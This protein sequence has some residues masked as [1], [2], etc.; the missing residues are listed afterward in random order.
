MEGPFCAPRPLVKENFDACDG[1][2]NNRERRGRFEQRHT[3]TE[4]VAFSK[5]P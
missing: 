4:E 1:L 2:L 3:P 5:G